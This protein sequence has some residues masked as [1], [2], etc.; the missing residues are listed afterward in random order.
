MSDSAPELAQPME[1]CLVDDAELLRTAATGCN[2]SL[3]RLLSNLCRQIEHKIAEQIPAR[4]AGQI[5]ACDILQ[6]ACVDAFLSF[7]DCQFRDL[8]GMRGWF[9]TIARRKLIDTLRMLQTRRRGGQ[10][11]NLA[12]INGGLIAMSVYKPDQLPPRDNAQGKQLYVLHSPQDF[13]KMRF[14]NLAIEQFSAAGANTKLQTY[15]GGH[16]WHGDVLG[17]IRRG[18]EWLAKE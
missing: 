13:I 15:E 17:N 12:S 1:E 3:G 14:P 7:G 9:D 4:F 6:Q 10:H 11:H 16:G 18:I 8:D 5:D 2:E